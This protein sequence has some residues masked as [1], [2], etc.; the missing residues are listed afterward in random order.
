MDRFRRYE[1]EFLNSSRIVS[2]GLR[3]LEATNGNVD[4]VISCSVEVDAEIGE[5]QLYLYVINLRR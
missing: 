2:R 4:A 3:Q 5:V 1:E